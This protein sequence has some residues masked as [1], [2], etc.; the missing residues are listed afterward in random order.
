MRTSER[1][2]RTFAIVLALIVVTALGVWWATRP[3]DEDRARAAVAKLA[4]I[5]RTSADETAIAR[6]A[7]VR[8]T[9]LEQVLPDARVEVMELES[10]SGGRDAL[11]HAS[12]AVP[13]AY[14]SASVDL[15]GLRATV[16]G[17]PPP[18]RARVE[19]NAKVA[20]RRRDGSDASDVRRFA[21]ELEEREGAFRVTS[22]TV[23][24]PP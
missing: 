6:A 23:W 8:S 4:T 14:E 9:V 5:V 1:G 21:V 13:S 20:G 16:S 10:A 17:S 2:I 18:K 11:L 24:P 7:R 15:V 19:G 12:L 3:S 22:I